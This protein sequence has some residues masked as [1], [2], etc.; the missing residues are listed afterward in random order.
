MKTLIFVIIITAQSFAQF[1]LNYSNNSYSFN[2]VFFLNRNLGWVVGYS[3]IILKTTD[4]GDNWTKLNTNSSNTFHSVY[5][6]N[7]DTGFVGAD[8]GMIYKTMDGGTTWTTTNVGTGNHLFSVY[9]IDKNVGFTVSYGAI[10]KTTDG[11][12]TWNGY[13]TGTTGLYSV[14]F[15][16]ANVG[17]VGGDDYILQTTDG[18]NSWDTVSIQGAV[19]SITAPDVNNIFS[20]GSDGQNELILKSTDGGN[21]WIRTHKGTGFLRL[22]S[23][24]AVGNSIWAVGN[25]N[26]ILKSIDSGTT[27]SLVNSATG[28]DILTSVYFVDPDYGWIS[29]INGNIQKFYRSIVTISGKVTYENTNNT[30]IVGA[31]VKLMNGTTVVATDTSNATG[32]YSFTG[33]AGA[34]NYTLIASKTTGWPSNAV[35]ASDALLAARN[36]IDPNVVL[37]NMQKLAA[38]VTDDGNVTAGDA[39]QILRRVVG[40]IT[41]F[42]IADWQFESKIVS[43]SISN[44]AADI[45]GI[46]AGDVNESVTT[47]SK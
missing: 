31:V 22:N 10:F 34:T 16:S 14:Y 36:S 28:Y 25:N 45:K 13:A 47:L 12:H 7:S 35:L 18:G 2:D 11:G 29:G 8:S 23:I 17:F 46:A 3:G 44:V 19:Y 39:L 26:R 6:I 15:P 30:P 41:S 1:T 43:V 32:D 40:Q 42:T 20:S 24:Q 9:F 27:W 21:T 5:F 38:D 37:S 33:V 4:G